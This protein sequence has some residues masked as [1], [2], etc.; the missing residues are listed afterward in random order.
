MQCFLHFALASTTRR[1][2]TKG[3]GDGEID[4]CTLSFMCLK[5]KHSFTSLIMLKCLIMCLSV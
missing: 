5:F 3:G 2:E 1:N 4:E